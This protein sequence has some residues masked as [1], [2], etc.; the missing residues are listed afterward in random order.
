MKINKKNKIYKIIN[1]YK[2]KS[3]EN[4][5]KH[6]DNYSQIRLWVGGLFC[7]REVM[8]DL[9]RILKPNDLGGNLICYVN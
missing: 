6:N 4:K 7:V 3:N 2:N 5:L 9:F 1:N 8:C